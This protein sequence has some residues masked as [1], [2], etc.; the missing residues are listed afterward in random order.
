LRWCSVSVVA[1]L[2]VL[3]LA[4]IFLPLAVGALYIAR[5]ADA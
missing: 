5:R 2:A 1:A 4:V 3:P